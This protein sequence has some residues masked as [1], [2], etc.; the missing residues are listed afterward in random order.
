MRFVL[1]DRPAIGGH[2]VAPDPRYA[3]RSKSRVGTA[4]MN[5]SMNKWMSLGDAERDADLDGSPG[6]G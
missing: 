5:R 6:D 1:L 4:A 3:T 2:W